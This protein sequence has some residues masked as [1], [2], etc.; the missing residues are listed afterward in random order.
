MESLTGAQLLILR[1]GPEL[2]YLCESLS[3]WTITKSNQKV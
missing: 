1:L 2:C 3:F